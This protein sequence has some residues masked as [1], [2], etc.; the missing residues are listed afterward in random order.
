[1]AFYDAGYREGGFEAGVRDALS[2]VWRARTSCI[3]RSPAKARARS[4]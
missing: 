4:R 1:M 2:A 3:A